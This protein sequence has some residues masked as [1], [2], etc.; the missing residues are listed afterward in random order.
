MKRPNRQPR[1]INST[2]Y[3]RPLHIHDTLRSGLYLPLSKMS[4]PHSQALTA[5]LSPYY[6]R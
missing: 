4:T 6:A 2:W 3:S 5:T 1:H